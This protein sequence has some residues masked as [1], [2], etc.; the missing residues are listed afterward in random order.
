MTTNAISGNLITLSIGGDL[1]AG[2]TNFTLS[3]NKA[4]IDVTSRDDTFQAAFLNGRRD[5][6]IDVEALYVYTDIAKKIL[7][8]EALTGSPASISAV[9]TMPDG[10]TFTGTVL[11]TSFSLN[12]PAEDA[13]TYSASFQGTGALTVSAS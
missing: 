4:T 7:M 3:A 8:T 13:V 5:W 2:S 12:M 10:A 6:T 9:I 1:I 11:C